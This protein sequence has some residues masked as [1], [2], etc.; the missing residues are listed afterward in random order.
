MYYSPGQIAPQFT[1]P[2]HNAAAGEGEVV[3][4][5]CRVLGRPSPQITWYKDGIPLEAAPNR[6]LYSQGDCHWLEFNDI[7]LTDHGEYTCVASNPAG[8][9][10]TSCRM[11]VE[12][13]SRNLT[14][15]PQRL[16]GLISYI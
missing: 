10:K 9:A 4:L 6:K 11:D 5:Q 14:K 13:R 16:S 1:Q 12:R 15:K 3:Q 2:L 7:Y 8:I